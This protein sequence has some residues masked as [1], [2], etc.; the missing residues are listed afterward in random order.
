[1]LQ[2]EAERLRGVT[3]GGAY[4]KVVVV[5]I[6]SGVSVDELNALATE[7]R[8]TN[9]ILVPHFIFL[10]N[11]QEQLKTAICSGQWL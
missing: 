7:P 4:T 11:V 1:M 9:V 3:S 8:D 10:Y 5:G 6:G 2:A